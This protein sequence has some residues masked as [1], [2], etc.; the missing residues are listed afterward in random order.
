MFNTK[1]FRAIESSLILDHLLGDGFRR[2]LVDGK[3]SLRR[4]TIAAGAVTWNQG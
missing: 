2:L 1:G 4:K 3:K